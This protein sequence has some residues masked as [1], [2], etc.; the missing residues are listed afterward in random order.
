MSRKDLE[1]ELEG[2]E[3]EANTSPIRVLSQ[4]LRRPNNRKKL[5]SERTPSPRTSSD[6]TT[7]SLVILSVPLLLPSIRIDLVKILVLAGIKV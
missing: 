4:A 7:A 3:N 5:R 1:K 6:F 2:G